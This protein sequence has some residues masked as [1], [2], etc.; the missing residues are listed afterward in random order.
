LTGHDDPTADVVVAE[1]V[2]RGAHMVRMDIGDFPAR[3]SLAATSGPRWEGRL[4]HGSTSVDLS[5]ITSVYYRRPTRFSFPDGL[6][7]GDRAFASA[8][9]RLGLGG[10]LAALDA[11]WVNDPMRV[12]AAE[13]KP[14]QLSIA[15]RVG[16]TVPRTLITND[17]GAAAE[18][19]R[20]SGDLVCKALSSLVLSDVEGAKG[21]YTSRIR[22]ADI[23]PDQLAATTHLIQEWVPKRYDTRVTMVG[24]RAH[25]VAI[26][27]GSTEGHT[28]WRTDYANLT[29]EVITSPADISAGMAAYLKTL[30]L[31]FGAFDFVVTPSGEW[32]FLECNPAGQWLW[33]QEEAGLPIGASLAELLATGTAT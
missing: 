3:L 14:L 6:S 9:A 5:A 20:G 31:H 26:H 27:A 18:F 25:A 24:E 8:E 21:I 23:D 7:D 2:Q 11:M 28:D 17:Y 30:G 19:A 10:V 29:Y 4:W 13:Y 15:A 33:L 1:L 22:V 12:A 16:L 32:V